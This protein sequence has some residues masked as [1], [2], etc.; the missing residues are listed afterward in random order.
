MKIASRRLLAGCLL[1]IG[2][3]AT[4]AWAHTQ[5]IAT[6]PVFPVVLSGADIGFRMNGRKGDTPV[7]HLVVRINGEWKQVEF[8]YGVKPVTK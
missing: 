1:I 8:A 5:V 3:L 6:Q 7:G 2:L 4:A